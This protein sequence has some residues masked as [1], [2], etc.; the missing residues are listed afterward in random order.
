MRAANALHLYLGLAVWAAWFVAAYGGLSVACMAFTPPRA[1]GVFNAINLG[2]MILTAGT[3]LWLLISGRRLN[4]ALRHL[5]AE[6][7]QR[8]RFI[9]SVSACL[10][11]AAAGATAFVGL[12]VL[13]LSPCL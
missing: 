5:P 2:L 6:A 7:P 13:V 1:A 3:A 9:G 10:Y 4:H 12:P 8:E 11:F